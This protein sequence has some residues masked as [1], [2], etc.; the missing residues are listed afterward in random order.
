MVRVK[1]CGITN[2]E[3]ALHAAAGGADAL[4]FVFYD[5]SPRFVTPERARAII[6]ALPPLVTCVGLFVN[7]APEK[8]RATA[9]QCGLDVIQLHGDEDPVAC[10]YPPYRVIKALRVRDAHSLADHAAFQVP[11]LLLDAWVPESYGGTG[12]LGNWELAKSVARERPVI[13]AG[14]LT[15]ENVA[16]AVRQVRPYGVDVSSGV[17]S[18]PG[19]RIR[20]RS[21]GLSAWPRRP[22]D[23]SQQPDQEGHFGQF[24]GRYVAETLMPALLELEQ[25]YREA[26]ADPLFQREFDSYLREYV[27]RPSPASSP[28]GATAQRETRRTFASGASA[29]APLAAAAGAG[30][31]AAIAPRTTRAD[32]V[33]EERDLE[34]ICTVLRR[35]A[36]L[37]L[38]PGTLRPG[39]PLAG[40]LCRRRGRGYRNSS[41]GREASG[42]AA[43]R[44]AVVPAARS[45]LL[46][47]EAV[48]RGRPAL[49]AV[50]RLLPLLADR[51]V[52]VGRPGDPLELLAAVRGR[53]LALEAHLPLLEAAVEQ[54]DR[55]LVV[56]PGL[57]PDLTPG[58]QPLRLVPTRLAVRRLV[59]LAQDAVAVETRD[60]VG[61]GERAARLDLPVAEP[62]VELTEL[63]RGAG[64]RSGRRGG[65]GVGARRRGRERRR[66][67]SATSATSRASGSVG[68]SVGM[69]VPPERPTLSSSARHEDAS[70]P[71]RC[72]P[73]PRRGEAV[74]GRGRAVAAAGSNRA[75][76]ADR[77]RRRRLP[78]HAP[79]D[80]SASSRSSS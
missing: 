16:D 1:I 80:S 5:K 61:A 58:S 41:G 79:Q 2:R 36:I 20:R 75:A 31:D 40:C 14:G 70:T 35:Q 69:V 23:M 76:R 68:W 17:E 37:G 32:R 13:L 29:Q 18:E 56:D 45:A 9:E 24:G 27:G 74:P 71:R 63:R 44:P 57:V 6:E 33:W 42:R 7:E 21:P 43:S 53:R 46:A 15:P 11:A 66:W 39:A 49:A 52:G 47:V 77:R 28:T 51:T 8:V 59:L 19:K 26:Q 48:E 50:G 67:R 4:G 65:R 54:Q 25:A 34:R 3:D 55:P 73:G 62:E 10:H 30:A 38:N 64:G 78:G 60:A 22:A 12:Q 72:E